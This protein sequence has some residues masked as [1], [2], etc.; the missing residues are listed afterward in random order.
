[1]QLKR[2][3]GRFTSA[4]TITMW[5]G[6][7]R[8]RRRRKERLAVR[9]MK[10][11][12]PK[13][14]H[15]RLTAYGMNIFKNIIVPQMGLLSGEESWKSPEPSNS[16]VSCSIGRPVLNPNF[17]PKYSF[18]PAL[19]F[20]VITSDYAILL[21]SRAFK[22]KDI[23]IQKPTF[24]LEPNAIF[25]AGPRHL[26]ITLKSSSYYLKKTKMTSHKIIAISHPRK[27]VEERSCVEI[28]LSLHSPP[29]NDADAPKLL[30]DCKYSRSSLMA[31][32][33]QKPYDQTTI[34]NHS[35][36]NTDQLCLTNQGH[37]TRRRQSA[38]MLV[39]NS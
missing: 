13:C 38:D 16:Q 2:A 10:G 14:P 17:M 27:S 1:V 30:D 18:T 33:D 21:F 22:T 24:I 34:A 8:N 29:R 23:L 12:H 19:T 31:S 39:Q 3:A 11:S 5:S 7:H 36:V 26:T 32:G 6:F 37:L 28:M 4:P 15:N 9:G 25:E 20:Q 35:C